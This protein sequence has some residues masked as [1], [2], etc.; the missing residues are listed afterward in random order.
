MSLRESCTP[1]EKNLPI[2]RFKLGVNKRNY[3]AT[4][5]FQDS[6]VVGLPWAKLCVGSNGNLHTI[7]CRICCEVKGKYKYFLSGIVFI[8]M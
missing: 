7:K 3:D 8:N 1:L 2:A 5:K 4:M 6:W